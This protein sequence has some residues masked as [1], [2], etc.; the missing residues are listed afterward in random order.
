MAPKK[1][2]WE[3]EEASA[4]CG[5]GAFAKWALM[6]WN[7]P[8]I[9][10]RPAI[11]GS[12]EGI[13]N[14][15]PS[16][17]NDRCSVIPQGRCSNLIWLGA[18]TL[19]CPELERTWKMKVKS[20][21]RVQLFETPWTV[22]YQA[23]LSMEFSRQEYWSGLPFPSP[24]D[25]PNPGIEPRSPTLQADTLPSEP[26]GNTS[27][28]V[29]QIECIF[30]RYYSI[31]CASF[32]WEYQK[33]KYCRNALTVLWSLFPQQDS[34]R[35]RPHLIHQYFHQQEPARCLPSIGLIAW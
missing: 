19:H 30:R 7:S 26:P 4:L 29:H 21:S 33:E 9:L 32:S 11:D 22:A 15:L 25:L 24:G 28:C 13:M 2:T 5:A 6:S 27:I 20:L 23:P 12:H 18:L 17:W 1:L 10:G 14:S 3:N 31:L 8:K 35:K 16:Q 34:R